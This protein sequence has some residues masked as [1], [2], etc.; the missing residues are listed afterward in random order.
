MAIF[1]RRNQCCGSTEQNKTIFPANDT[2]IQ[3]ENGEKFQL[4][5]MSQTSTN[6]QRKSIKPQIDKRKK[7][8]KKTKRI[9]IKINE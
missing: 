6:T 8:G 2:S 5:K 9:E 7:V 3:N 1:I 4:G